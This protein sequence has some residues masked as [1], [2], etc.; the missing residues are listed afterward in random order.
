MNVFASVALAL[1][2]RTIICTKVRS[3]YLR[4]R[5]S[6][7][8]NKSYLLHISL[9]LARIWFL[10]WWI[11]PLRK[12]VMFVLKQCNSLCFFILLLILWFLNIFSSALRC[13]PH[14]QPL[15]VQVCQLCSLSDFCTF[16]ASPQ[17]IRQSFHVITLPVTSTWAPAVDLE[18]W[19]P[20]TR[21]TVFLLLWQPMSACSIAI[22]SVES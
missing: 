6:C 9:E 18:I 22:K 8:E 12:L 21:P 20:S 13:K 14:T 10:G 19:S 3:A 11:A 15:N 16:S 7:M 5:M 4:K 2:V 17:K 1:Y